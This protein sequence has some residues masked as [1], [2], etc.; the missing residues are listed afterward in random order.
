[1]PP[2]PV[3]ITPSVLKWALDEAGLT[4]R[5]LAKQLDVKAADVK[6]WLAGDAQPNT[7]Q[8]RK[9]AKILN[10]P[11]VF[12][13]QP[14]PPKSASVV[15]QFRHHV[16]L[17]SSR[18]FNK[19]EDKALRDARRYQNVVS[20]L[21]RDDPAF[22]PPAC[23]TKDKPSAAS[24]KVRAWLEWDLVEDQQGQ[25]TD[26]KVFTR[27]RERL[28]GRGLLIML[29]NLGQDG[30][31]GFAIADTHAPLI[32]VNSAQTPAAR[33]FTLLHELGHVLNDDSSF[34]DS[35]EVDA[36]GLERWCDRFAAT[37][38]LP[39]SEV[40]AYV[41]GRLGGSV[42]DLSQAGQVAR[43]FKASLAATC[44]RLNE[45][46]LSESDLRWTVPAKDHWKPAD[47]SGFN[48]DPGTA[49]NRV[50]EIGLGILREVFDAEDRADLKRHDVQRYL[51]LADDH[52][53]DLLHRVRD[54]A[55]DDHYQDA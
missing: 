46:S 18:T 36:S 3:P 53:E 12:F 10:R 11:T 27:L 28:E 13:L 43:R 21:R 4:N 25:S 45:L 49:A 2:Q 30:C 44:I 35:F 39:A 26:N 37:F 16:H 40:R 47:E 1:M 32:L 48:P 9:L 24:E 19:K 50:R 33:S 38:L 6:N 55:S 42:R 7:G 22:D 14:T 51:S 34:D 31:R 29:V 5:G 17:A 54:S 23:T 52:Y 8:F 41:K 20:W 15:A